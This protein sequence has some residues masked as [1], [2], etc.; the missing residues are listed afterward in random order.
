MSLPKFAIY[1]VW[2]END[3]G[4]RASR[5]V[6]CSSPHS[7]RLPRSQESIRPINLANCWAVAMGVS[8]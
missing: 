3:I 2:G 7:Y 8:C 1:L 6:L 5:V 4:M